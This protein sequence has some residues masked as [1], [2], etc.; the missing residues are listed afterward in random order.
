MGEVRVSLTNFIAV[1]LMAFVAVWLLNRGLA[2]ANL[3]Q[4]QA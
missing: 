2:R 1:G 3:T 4:Y